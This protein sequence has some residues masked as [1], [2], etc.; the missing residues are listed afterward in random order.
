MSNIKIIASGSYI[1]SI[2]VTNE[3][4]EEKYNVE[5]GYIIKMT[6]IKQRFY[7]KEDVEE[8]AIKC[9]KNTLNNLQEKIDLIIVA[10]TTQAEQ[11]PSVSYKIQKYFNIEDCMC[12]D[13]LAGCAGFINAFDIAKMY[14]DSN[15]VN[16][17]LVIGVE[18]L[19]HYIDKNDINTEILLA[20]GAGAVVIKKCDD[21]K[22]YDSYIRSNGQEGEILTTSNSLN[23][24]I[25]MNGK[26]VYKYAVKE[27]VKNVKKLLEE[28]NINIDDIKYIIPHQSN[29]RIL[30]SMSKKLEIEPRKMYSN[31]ENIGNTFCA[32]IPIALDEILKSNKL[33]ENDKIILLG[34]GGGLNTGSIL[35]EI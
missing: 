26:E 30:T 16:T 9:A 23:S 12:M 15:K 13:I 3:E 14:I 21:T 24:K 20:D 31:V 32:S 5:N 11:M 8:L 7:A 18:K 17:A 35:L 25:Y 34:Y 4:L 19:S 27:T 22:L 6:G 33:Q 29:M 1:P 28:N 2:K 10:S